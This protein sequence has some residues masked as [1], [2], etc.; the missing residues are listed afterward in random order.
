[1]SGPLY[2]PPDAFADNSGDP[3][4]AADYLELAA[5]FSPNG[6]AFSQSITDALELSAEE[7]FDTVDKELRAREEAA[8][9]AVAR[10]SQR[11][12][13]LGSAYPFAVDDDGDVITFKESDLSFGNAA[14]LVSLILSHLRSVSEVLN[15]TS[16]YPT[17]AE[18]RDLRNYFQYLATAGLAAEIGG[19]AWSFGHPRPDGSGFTEKLTEIW[20][21]LRDGCVNRDPSAPTRPKDDQVDVFA[22]REHRDGLP[23]F[24]LAAAQ[25]ATGANWKDKSV[26]TQVAGVFG[27]RW[28]N[29][30]PVTVLVAYHI[31]PF[32]RPDEKFR[33]D[34]LLLGNILH[35]IR[36]PRRVTEAEELAAK[37]L[38]IEAFDQL[39]KI[40][41][42]LQTYKHR[43]V[44]E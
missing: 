39:P 16:L 27:A 20:I 8:S 28:F 19:P 17:E 12:R 31:V 26:K 41:S 23:G 37:G 22:W 40:V 36:L 15:G 10:I 4:L 30:Q 44:S 1:M 24:L 2:L 7:D 21:A 43:G 34:V 9:G 35:R 5:F 25:V 13:I 42:W 6:Q 3:D 11:Q 38:T 33:D 14:Y 29:P 18:I 32:A